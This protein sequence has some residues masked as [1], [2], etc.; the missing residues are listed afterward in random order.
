[1]L[2]FQV[3]AGLVFVLTLHTLG[4]QHLDAYDHFLQDSFWLCNDVQYR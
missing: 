1:M 4:R 3:S 2:R